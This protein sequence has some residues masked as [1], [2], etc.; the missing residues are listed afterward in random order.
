MPEANLVE[1]GVGLDPGCAVFQLV[2]LR[3]AWDQVGIQPDGDKV[4]C[5]GDV[6][7]FENDGPLDAAA[8]EFKREEGTQ[9]GR[10]RPARA[11]VHVA[12]NFVVLTGLRRV[13]R[14]VGPGLQRVAHSQP[15]SVAFV[16]LERREELLGA[17]IRQGIHVKFE[18]KCVRRGIVAFQRAAEDVTAG[19]RFVNQRRAQVAPENDRRSLGRVRQEQQ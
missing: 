13:E 11:Q 3:G 19:F 4:V 8:W 9:S 12:E 16:E 10:F 15:F 6:L 18:I 2:L 14:A 5:A 17:H 7:D 1:R